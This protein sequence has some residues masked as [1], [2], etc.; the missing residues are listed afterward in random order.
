MT[1]VSTLGSKGI[2]N[3]LWMQTIANQ[4]YP[5]HRQLTMQQTPENLPVIHTFAT[6]MCPR[7]V[8]PNCLNILESSPI[9]PRL[10]PHAHRQY[11]RPT[12]QLHIYRGRPL[13]MTDLSNKPN[14]PTLSIQLVKAGLKSKRRSTRGIVVLLGGIIRHA[15]RYV[16]PRSYLL[17]EKV[18]S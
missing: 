7:Q 1:R 9:G 15:Y 11:H 5:Q 10:S 13:S 16:S 18:Y 8:H 14:P 12:N 4:R 6:P 3:P 17:R 2:Y